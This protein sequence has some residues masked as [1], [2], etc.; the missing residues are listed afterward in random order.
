MATVTGQLK[1]ASIVGKPRDLMD[2]IFT[3]APTDT[4][5]FSMC[6]KSSASQTLH[7][8]QTDDLAAPGEN[9]RVEG[10]ETTVFQASATEELNNRTQILGKAVNVSGTAQAVDQAGVDDQ[11]EYQTALRMKELKK[12][13]EYALLQN[14]LD[15]ADNGTVGRLMKGLPCWLKTSVDLGENGNAAT[16]SAVA[17]AGTLRVPTEAMLKQVLADIYS[18]GGNP[19]TVL[20]APDIRVTMS[21]ILNGG[22]T[23]MENVDKQKVTATIDVYISDF[24]TVKLVPN[25]VQA[26]VPYSQNCAFVLDPDYWKVAYLRG[27]KEEKLGKTGDNIKGHIIVECT[28]EARQ[29]KSSGMIADLKASA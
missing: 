6:G 23:R 17:T 21:E 29:P 15:R 3:V 4:P 22:A 9:S 11:Y 13:V 28:L 8:W 14:K 24:G 16:N 12:D 25:R 27:F 18:E 10:S 2:V 1:D 5:F 26:N 7:E 20:M 19:D